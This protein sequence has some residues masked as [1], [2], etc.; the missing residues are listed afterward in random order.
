MQ[1]TIKQLDD[2]MVL[3]NYSQATRKSYVSAVKNFYKWCMAH[4]NDADFDK[5]NAHRMYLIER[6]KSGVAWQTVNGGLFRN[7]YVIYQSAQPRVGYR[8]NT[9]AA[10]RK[11]LAICFIPARSEKVDR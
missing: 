3:S 5:P 9:P 8:K 6:S 2:F 1:K 10:E 7:S 4:M 11:I